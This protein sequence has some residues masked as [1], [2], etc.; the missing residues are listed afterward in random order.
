MPNKSTKRDPTWTPSCLKDA[1]S[2]FDDSFCSDDYFSEIDVSEYESESA[3]SNL[4]HEF[5][6]YELVLD[7][8][9]SIFTTNAFEDAFGIFGK[10]LAYFKTV[11]EKPAEEKIEQKDDEMPILNQPYHFYV[12]VVIEESPKKSCLV[13]EEIEPEYGPSETGEIV[14][15]TDDDVPPLAASTPI[16]GSNRVLSTEQSTMM[17][18]TPTKNGFLSN[19]GLMF[20]PAT[21]PPALI[22]P[23]KSPLPKKPLSATSTPTQSSKKK[24]FSKHN[25]S[26]LDYFKSVNE[27]D[28]D[29]NAE[30]H[31]SSNEEVGVVS[32]L[33]R[34]R[35]N[36]MDEEGQKE[37]EN[38]N[39]AKK[40]LMIN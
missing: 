37:Q 11:L 8:Q 17:A 28:D 32:T 24:N 26:I 14:T 18:S 36:E 22:S 27:N 35:T 20:N 2:T 1:D 21:A 4:E 9:N 5:P 33:K 39:P 40:V 19:M 6:E 38:I 29:K 12:N 23:F 10:H 15:P 34:K 16:V 3:E 7:H 30:N 13:L 25:K 31:N